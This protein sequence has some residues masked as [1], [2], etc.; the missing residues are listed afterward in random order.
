M[1][2]PQIA[3]EQ[4][5]KKKRRWSETQ[6]VFCVKKQKICES[7]TFFRKKPTFSMLTYSGTIVDNLVYCML[8]GPALFLQETALI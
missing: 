6:K 5:V 2:M 3:R 7:G 8:A 1:K 4:D